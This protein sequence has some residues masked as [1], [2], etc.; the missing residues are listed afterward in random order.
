[1]TTTTPPNYSR[2]RRAGDLIFVSGQ[3]GRDE[4]GR[5]DDGLHAQ[6][7]H[8]LRNVQ[9]VLRQQGADLCDVINCRV[10]LRSIDDWAAMNEEYLKWFSDPLPTRTTIACDLVPG[11]VVEID[12]VAQAP[13]A[14]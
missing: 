2:A 11:A 5:Y 14:D 7:A 3:L 13:A 4:E 8:A 12:V 1:M 9:D 6:L 10:Y